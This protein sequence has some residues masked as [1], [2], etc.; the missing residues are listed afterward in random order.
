MNFYGNNQEKLYQNFN[1]EEFNVKKFQEVN[2][3]KTNNN[4]ASI[5]DALNLI[6]VQI[7]A[8]PMIERQKLESNLASGLPPTVSARFPAP[9]QAASNSKSPAPL[10]TYGGERKLNYRQLSMSI[11]DSRVKHYSGDNDENSNEGLMNSYQNNNSNVK[12]SK[13]KGGDFS[14]YRSNHNINPAMLKN[15]PD[16]KNYAFTLKEIQQ[17]MI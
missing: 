13:E 6:Q 10:G 9:N 1:I 11:G 16:F 5:T 12:L 7:S 8:I 14:S 3:L 17:K 4:F 2:L 15:T